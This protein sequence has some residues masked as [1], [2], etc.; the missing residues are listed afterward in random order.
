M[1]ATLEAHEPVTPVGNPLNVAPVAP[2]V[3]N[4]I[5]GIA[6]FWHTVGLVPV[7]IVFKGFTIIV[8][9]ETLIAAQLFFW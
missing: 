6:T 3:A 8:C 5:A 4:K 2:V 1:V 9:S 7:A